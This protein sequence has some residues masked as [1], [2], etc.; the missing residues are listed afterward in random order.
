MNQAMIDAHQHFWRLDRGDYRWLTPEHGELYRNFLPADLEPLLVERGIERTILVQAADSDAETD[1]LLAIAR[2]TPFVAGVVGWV[3]LEARTA[4]LR[5]RRLAREPAF[6]G[7][8]PMIQDLQDDGWMLRP[9]LAAAFE[10][11][12]EEELVF[13]AL[14]RIQ[15]LP[16]LRELLAR[17]PRMRVVVDHAA[18]PVVTTG[19]RPWL[20]FTPWR[21]QMEAIAQESSACCKVSGL[22]SEA[23]GDWSA[24]DF[25]PYFEVLLGAFGPSRLLWGSDWPLVEAAGGYAAWWDATHALLGDLQEPDRLAILGGNAARMYRL[26]ERGLA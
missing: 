21:E 25:Q 11:I 24:W 2:D 7:V 1:F 5:I 8:R 16:A 18:K 9:G 26:G 22:P 14:V 3:D 10:A 13:D 12:T 15:H 4:P 20:G 6:V 19:M 23:E 17:H